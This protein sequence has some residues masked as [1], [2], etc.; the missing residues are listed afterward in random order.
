M[1]YLGKY[2]FYEGGWTVDVFSFWFLGKK[3]NGLTYHHLWK[4]RYLIGPEME[5]SAGKGKIF[6]KL[7]G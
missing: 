5:S 7:D 6:I 4:K 2:Y 1:D 3:L